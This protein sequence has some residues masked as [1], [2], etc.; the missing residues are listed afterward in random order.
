[1]NFPTWW[2]AD[3]VPA[4]EIR[5][6]EALGLRAVATR[7][8]MQVDPGDGSKAITTG[9][10]D[11]CAYTYRRASRSRD[12]HASI[13]VVYDLRFEEDGQVVDVPDGLPSDLLTLQRRESVDVPV[14]EIQSRVTG[15]S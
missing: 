1:M 10:S 2:W 11:A 8:S 14:R 13:T 12:Y 9:R 15:T 5:G 7:R 4:G 6:S 3:G